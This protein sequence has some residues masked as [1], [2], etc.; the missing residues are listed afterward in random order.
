MKTLFLVH[1]EETFRNR[2]D[3]DMIDNII[4]SAALYD[5]VIHFT[6]MVNDE[7]PV[8]E[9]QPYITKEIQWG[10]GYEPACFEYDKEELD[11]LID[12]LG[13]EFTWIPPYLRN[14][15]IREVDLGGG[16]DGECLTDMESVLSHLNID[17]NRKMKFIYS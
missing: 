15:N 17:Y 5:Q 7:E 6:S 14:Y 10:W 4:K 12:S 16:C 3:D 11:Y 1:I 8:E 9:L 2:F 13:H